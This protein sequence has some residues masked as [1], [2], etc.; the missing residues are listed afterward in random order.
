VRKV[1]PDEDQEILQHVCITHT[2]VRDELHV[3]LRAWVRVRVVFGFGGGR[4]SEG[5]GLLSLAEDLLRETVLGEDQA[6]L[7]RHL[8]HHITGG[9]ED[10]R[11]VKYQRRCQSLKGRQ[12]R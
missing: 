2:S 9:G 12:C 6:L 7:G 5:E 1:T 10:L 11:T 8:L 4:T 3:L